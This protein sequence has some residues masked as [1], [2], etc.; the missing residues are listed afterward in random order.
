MLKDVQP[1]GA[2]LWK[3]Q[4]GRS[5]RHSAAGHGPPLLSRRAASLTLPMAVNTVTWSGGCEKQ[6]ESPGGLTLELEKL[7]RCAHQRHTHGC[8]HRVMCIP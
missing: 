4:M 2:E 6:K 5:E 3:T 8:V 1:W 7:Q